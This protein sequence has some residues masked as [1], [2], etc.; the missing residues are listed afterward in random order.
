[1]TLGDNGKTKI[2]RANAEKG[3]LVGLFEGLKPAAYRHETLLRIPADGGPVGLVFAYVDEKNYGLFVA[4]A[5]AGTVRASLIRDGKETLVEE[6]KV[7]V[8]TAKW[9]PMEL[10]AL[11]GKIAFAFGEDLE[12]EVTPGM[13]APIPAV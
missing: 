5:K 10:T 7:A 11:E 3:T 9:V 6:K 4:N 2:L 8:E 12:F 1:M 13:S